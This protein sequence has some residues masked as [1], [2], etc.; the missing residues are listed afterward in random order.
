MV[1]PVLESL[2]AK[3]S[4]GSGELERCLGGIDDKLSPI[5]FA[6]RHR[7]HRFFPREISRPDSQI[8]PW[9]AH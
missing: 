5:N 3:A 4:W 9:N 2:K 8:R 7:R 1:L 6:N